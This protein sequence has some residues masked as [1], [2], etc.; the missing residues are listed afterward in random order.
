MVV[1]SVASSLFNRDDST[2]SSVL[3][4]EQE[5][6]QSVSLLSLKKY[7]RFLMASTSLVASS[8]AALSHAVSVG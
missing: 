5:A 8:L 7:G 4:G 2:L 1:L 3:A 6:A